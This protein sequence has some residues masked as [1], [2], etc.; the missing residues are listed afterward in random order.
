M[1]RLNVMRKSRAL[2][3]KWESFIICFEAWGTL[4]K[5]RQ[6][7][8]HS[9]RIGR[10]VL[11]QCRLNMTRLVYYELMAAVVLAPNY[12]RIGPVTILS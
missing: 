9:Q 4:G 5:R 2:L 11:K 7:E 3:P 1:H 8:R 12:Y 10:S 6:K